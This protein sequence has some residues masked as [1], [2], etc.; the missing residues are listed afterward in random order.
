MRT[1]LRLKGEGGDG[2][3]HRLVGRAQDVDGVDLNRIDDAD[4]P[5]DPAVR[6]EIAID[7]FP[8][9]RQQLFR[10]VQ[11][12]VPELFR[13]NNR[14]RHDRPR[15]RAAARFVDPGDGG[16]TEGAQFPFMT[17]STAPIH[18]GKILKR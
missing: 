18:G 4:R 9:L 13:K 2:R 15:E 14:G 12:P 5:C 6:D 1:C 17:K 16:D 10:V 7:F 11:L 8:L 3:A